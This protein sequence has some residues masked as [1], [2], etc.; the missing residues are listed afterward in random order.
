MKNCLL[1]QIAFVLLIYAC[2]NS[3]KRN[4]Q[5]LVLYDGYS[6]SESLEE[7]V[8]GNDDNDHYSSATESN[9]ADIGNIHLTGEIVQCNKCMGY[10]S[11]QDGQYGQPQIC[12][13]CWVSTNMRI[14]QGWTGFN[15]RFGE[16]DAVFNSL[17]ADYF[18]ELDMSGASGMQN[19]GGGQSSDQIEAEIAWHENN[20]AQLEHQLEYIE[21]SVNRTYLEQQLIEE[22][23]EVKRLKNLLNR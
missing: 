9:S 7:Q 19:D 11:V 6:P 4:S 2:G 12:K 23:Y 18:D 14:Q 15:G 17:P 21:G 1:F 20:I 16:V 13:F 10:G 8:G 22:R 3:P 5:E